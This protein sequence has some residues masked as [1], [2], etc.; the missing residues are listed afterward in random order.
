M[1]FGF[2][3]VDTWFGNGAGGSYGY[4]V[5]QWL[6]AMLGKTGAGFVVVV[7]VILWLVIL[8]YKVVVWFN[9]LIDSI[10][11]RKPKPV[12]DTYAAAADKAAAV[13]AGI[14]AGTDADA[15]GLRSGTVPDQK[16]EP[17]EIIFE[18]E[19]A[20][21]LSGAAATGAV[22]DAPL[23][24][25]TTPDGNGV[26]NGNSSFEIEGDDEDNENG[27]FLKTLPKGSLETLFD[28]RLDLPDYQLPPLSLLD[29]YKNMIYKGSSR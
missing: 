29:D 11:H 21:V 28:P 17:K 4:F 3:K 8:S 23:R 26:T 9:R 5:N 10:F 6:M 1:F 7:L 2:T 22:A 15:S 25:K 12:S 13:A 27:D 18:I 24:V 16:S 20:S 14:V 19:G